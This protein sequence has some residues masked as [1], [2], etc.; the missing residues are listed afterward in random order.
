MKRII[1][2]ILSLVA[3]AAACSKSDDSSSGSSNPSPAAEPAPESPTAAPIPA[4]TDAAS[5]V[6]YGGVIQGVV[7]LTI[8]APPES[9]IGASVLVEG[10][11]ELNAKTAAD[12][13]YAIENVLPG[14]INLFVLSGEGAAALRLTGAGG[15]SAYGI[16]LPDVVV[17]DGETI[18]LGTKELKKTGGLTAKVTFFENPNSLS[19]AGTDIFVPG[20]AFIAK[21][22]E[23]GS[24]SLAGLPEGLYSVYFA[25][26]GFAVTK[27]RD[28]Q[29][30]SG[31]ITDLG[32]VTL[33][34]ST[35]PEGSISVVPSMTATINSQ[36][37]KIVT[38]K[39]VNVGLIFDSDAA[40][41]K[42]SDEPS[43][44]NRVWKPVANTATFDFSV[45]SSYPADGAKVL[46]VMFSDLNGLESSPFSDEFI[47]DTENPVLSGAVILNSWAQTSTSLNFVDLVTADS[48]SGVADVK[49]SLVGTAFTDDLS[50][51]PYTGRMNVSLGAASG[52][53]TLYVKVRDYT[54]RE[55][56]ITSDS[57]EKG[58]RTVIANKVYGNK[59]TLLKAQS[60]YEVAGPSVTFNGDL[61]IEAGATLY[62]TNSLIVKGVLTSVGTDLTA[63][64]KVLIVDE[65]C[66]GM[67]SLILDEG[68]PGV[69]EKNR[70]SYT[71][72]R[73]VNN[74][75]MNGG[76]VTYNYFNST[77]CN[78]SGATKGII[79]KTGQDPLTLSNND[80]DHWGIALKTTTG[81]GTKVKGNTGDTSIFVRQEGTANNT[82][83]KDNVITGS[84]QSLYSLLEIEAGTIVHSGNVFDGISGII[85]YSGASPYTI[86]GLDVRG[87]GA[88]ASTF[89]N[90]GLLTIEDSVISGCNFAVGDAVSGDILFQY[91]DFSVKKAFA[92]FGGTNITVDFIRNN[93]TCDNTGD[94]GYCDL[95]RK[96]GGGV[97][98][99]SFANNNIFCVDSAKCRGGLINVGSGNTAPPGTFGVS[100]STNHWSSK[101]PAGVSF[102]TNP[103]LAAFAS[104][105]FFND[106][107]FQST[108]DVTFIKLYY[109]NSPGVPG[110]LEGTHALTGD[111]ST[112][113]GLQTAGPRP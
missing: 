1:V 20:T 30:V 16:K 98:D 66:S 37:R 62:L 31:Q 56:T 93:L 64:G 43:F 104:A 78:P 13:S 36:A 39:S 41:M 58:A 69:S 55:S 94:P 106:A 82:E 97:S 53:K 95:L 49:F 65:N 102:V 3:T 88:F 90:S 101:A 10:R 51:V 22:D 103:T 46:Y 72:F 74:I 6:S 111:Y 48:G 17:K 81:N 83:I 91:N 18:D 44:L 8:D 92:N 28:V 100:F 75:E 14:Q 86:S 112:S 110:V 79:S 5:G 32:S 12:G 15:P 63:T 19:L 47:I 68:E 87:C 61:E 84:S 96:N 23:A 113:Y 29:I 107:T 34:I 59:V 60:P 108:S 21:S 50:W 2:G 25:H 70:V 73:D 45:D 7:A 54:G 109:F 89:N 11:P 57:I 42:I 33:S 4:P 77:I 35:G 105:P 26:A 99:I 9:I 85:K 71:E 40:L 24:F 52:L 38:S 67:N 27:L 80:F 76:E